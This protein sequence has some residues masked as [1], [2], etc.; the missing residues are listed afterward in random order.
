MSDTENRNSLKCET[1]KIR[2][3]AKVKTTRIRKKIN[4]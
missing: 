1:D 4:R 2:K 3:M